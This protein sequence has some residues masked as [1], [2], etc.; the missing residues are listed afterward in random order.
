MEN[1]ADC[2]PKEVTEREDDLRERVE[3]VCKR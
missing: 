1:K 3:G 2:C